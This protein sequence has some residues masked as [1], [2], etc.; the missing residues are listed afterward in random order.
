[1]RLYF[2]GAL[3]LDL[4]FEINSI[5]E[6]RELL[7]QDL[8]PGREYV[9]DQET[10]RELVSR[11]DTSSCLRYRGGGGSAANTSTILAALGWETTF[12]GTV[13]SDPEGDLVLA[14]MEG[15]GLET[16]KRR[17]KTA[18]CIILVARDH[19]DRIILVAPNNEEGLLLKDAP[20]TIPFLHLSSLV[21]KNGLEFHKGLVK[22]LKH[23]AI[24]SMDPGEIY[25]K[26]GVD[27]LSS[28]LQRTDILFI[29]R[30]ELRMLTG[31][32]DP[33]AAIPFLRSEKDG[34]PGHPMVVMKMGERGAACYF[35]GKGISASPSKVHVVDNTGA[36]DAFDA[37]F[38]NAWLR[39][40]EPFECLREGVNLAALSLSDWGRA[41][42]TRLKE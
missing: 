24:L 38:L 7:N 25:S 17:G 15:V 28:M 18:I 11:L 8:V 36:G 20:G 21:S 5:E 33:M 30:D 10:A 34:L 16:L 42:I 39:G 35:S 31:R 12:L 41:W 6:A 29:T 4:I 27:T 13:G 23:E 3:N 2:S 40:K 26:K 22:R 1:M 19:R 37:G 9:I 32:K 14:S